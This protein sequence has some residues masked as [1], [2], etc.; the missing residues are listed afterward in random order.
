MTSSSTYSDNALYRV[1]YPE[2]LQQ[3]LVDELKSKGTEYKP[4]T[5]HTSTMESPYILTV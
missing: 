2:E 1:T 5:K 3:R 4:R